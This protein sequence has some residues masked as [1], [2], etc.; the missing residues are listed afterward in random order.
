MLQIE[1]VPTEKIMPKGTFMVPIR[2][3]Y[4][5]IAA[6]ARRVGISQTTKLCS[7]WIR[8]RRKMYTIFV[9]NLLF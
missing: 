2:K 1:I 9:N 7:H 4:T 5:Q 8:Q 3:K 6:N